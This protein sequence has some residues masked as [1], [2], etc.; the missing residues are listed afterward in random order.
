[1]VAA[2]GVEGG[3]AMGTSIAGAE[4]CVDGELR[5]A[6]SAEDGFCIPPGQRPDC[7]GVARE[8]LMAVDAGIVDSAAAHL[9]GNHIRG[10]VIVAAAGAGVQVEAM[11]V[12]DDCGGGGFHRRRVSA[13][14]LAR[15]SDLGN[16]GLYKTV[17]PLSGF[18]ERETG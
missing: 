6:D 5:A 2:A 7:S 17:D 14:I 16:A 11:D 1:V 12:R 9:D 10:S 15:A 13:F 3:F 4:V 8:R 18:R